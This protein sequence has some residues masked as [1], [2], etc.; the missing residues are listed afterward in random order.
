VIAVGGVANP[1]WPVGR[2]RPVTLPSRH[3]GGRG[4]LDWVVGCTYAGQPET[5]Q[6]VRNLMGCNM[7]FRRE[8]FAHVGGF[9]EDLGRVGKTPLGCE[10]TEL[11]IRARAAFPG[12]KIIFEPHA[13]VEH[14]VSVD[15]LSWSYLRHRCYAEGLSKAAVASM[16]GSEQALETERDYATKILPRGLVRELGRAVTVPSE[17]TTALSGAAA[18]VVAL[19]ATVVGYLRARLSRTQ[20]QGSP[21]PELTMHTGSAP[22]PGDAAEPDLEPPRR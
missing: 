7:S 20:V 12:T 21:I 10:E 1:G 17:R 15:R 22:R 8:V 2:H 18:I 19:S 14:Q 3:V 9:S 4:E 13:R 11:C 6:P 5:P 16:V